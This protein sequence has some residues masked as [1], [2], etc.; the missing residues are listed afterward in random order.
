MQ[1]VLS[2][3]QSP[4]C[5]LIENAEL[6]T[7]TL[8]AVIFG[9]ASAGLTGILDDEY[10]RQLLLDPVCLRQ[11]ATNCRATTD[12]YY[13]VSQGTFERMQHDLLPTEAQPFIAMCRL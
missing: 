6:L 7:G 4:F 10:V 3:P 5:R 8:Q 1:L 11:D 2:S 12:P 13:T 9:S